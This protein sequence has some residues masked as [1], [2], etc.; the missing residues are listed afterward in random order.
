M[1]VTINGQDRTA[2]L[3]EKIQCLFLERAGGP[4]PSGVSPPISASTLR[5]MKS[6]AE[7]QETL[8]RL[9]PY[10]DNV[11]TGPFDIPRRPG[12]A[13]ALWARFKTMLWRLLRY[14]HDRITFRQNLINSLFSNALEFEHRLRGREL[15]ELRRRVAELEARQGTD[16]DPSQP[17]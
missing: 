1:N 16:D 5:G 3:R 11:G 8:L 15:D 9:L 4:E 2:E 14:Q 17:H 13:G 7:F 12:A 10:R 6:E